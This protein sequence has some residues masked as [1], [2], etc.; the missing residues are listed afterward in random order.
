MDCVSNKDFN[1]FLDDVRTRGLSGEFETQGYISS[2]IVEGFKKYGIY[3]AM[4]PKRFGGLEQSPAEF[5][6]LIEKISEADGS[7]GWV[8]S[9]GMSPAY[10]GALPVKTLE[11]LYSKTPDII[12]AGG[13]FP[14]QPAQKS[15]NQYCV[16]GRWKFSSGCMSA[17]IVGVG[18][19]PMEGESA[20]GLPR[21]AVLPKQDVEIDMTWD[22][23]GLRGTGS[24]DLVVNNQFVDEDWTFIRGSAS[25][26]DEPFFRYPSL[27]FATQVLVITGA[28]IT[29][30]AI[31]QFKSMAE[32]RSI[33]GGVKMGER[34]VTQF[35]FAQLVARFEGARSWFYEAIN[36]T[37]ESILAGNA[38]SKEQIMQMRLS[39]TQLTRTCSEVTRHLQLMAGMSAIYNGHPLAR[40]VNDMNVL[41]QHAFM[42]DLTFQNAGAVL[43]GHEPTPGFL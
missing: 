25:Q 38:P 18:I 42:G 36:Q 22:T 8:A 35:N 30:A 41:T 27:S 23:V 14:P 13:I 3:R 17:D 40:Y 20:L 6:R 37:W 1:D 26:L 7:A 43:F 9:F 5:C 34:P 11:K 12:F 28:G 21:M 29:Q 39:S 10:F 2:D 16:S 4:V 19:M 33:T 15:N 24:H 31:K 32:G